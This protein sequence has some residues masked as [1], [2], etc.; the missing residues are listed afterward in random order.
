MTLKEYNIK[1]EEAASKSTSELQWNDS[2]ANNAI[3]M[4]E[5]FKHA[6]NIM[7]YC[8][9]GSIFK[10]D[11]ADKVNEEVEVD[12]YNPMEDL[13]R[14]IN[15]F[16]EKENTKL[17][18]ILQKGKNM[19]GLSTSIQEAWNK[20]IENGGIILHKLNEH[21]NPQFHFSI[22]DDRMYRR[23]IGAEEH[24]AFAN[25]NDCDCVSMLKLQFDYLLESSKK[26]QA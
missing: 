13:Y 5:M 15:D 24:N 14:Q 6:N 18:I 19:E 17:T 23:E 4:K 8:G 22:G 9:E 16:L 7:M 26:I 2:R 10:Q 1:V 20:R 21:L 25:F 12:D 11:F 3:I